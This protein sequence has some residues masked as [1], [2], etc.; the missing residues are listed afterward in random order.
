VDFWEQGNSH[1]KM[2]SVSTLLPKKKMENWGSSILPSRKKMDL[3]RVLLIREAHIE[4]RK[5]LV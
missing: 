5:Y 1:T 2:N 4:Q 3:K